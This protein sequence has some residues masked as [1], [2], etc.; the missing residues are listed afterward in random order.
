[1]KYDSSKDRKPKFTTISGLETKPMLE[2]Y[3]VKEDELG[4]PGE[5]PFTRGVYP[6]M[7]RGRPWTMRQFAGFGSPED[8]NKR[9]H[10]LLEQGIDGLST[11]FD[12]PTLMGYDSD[13]KMSRGEVGRE[14]VSVSSIEDME[15][16]FKGIKL[17]EVSTSMTINCTAPS[18]LA[19]YFAVAKRGGAKLEELAG[20]IQNDILKEFIAQKEWVSPPEPSVRL[21]CD[22]IEFCTEHAPKF[23]PVSISGYHISCLLYTSPSPR[24]AT[25]S[26]MPSSA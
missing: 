2:S 19:M 14:G 13:H 7:Y 11:A 22:V 9:F 6:S 20:T 26:R 24:D 16:L 15:R 3:K 12:M 25:L 8:T 21:A 4:S 23:H 1:M 18:V 5:Y 10:Y 17:S